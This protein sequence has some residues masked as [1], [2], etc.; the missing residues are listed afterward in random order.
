[1]ITRFKLHLTTL[2]G[3]VVDSIDITTDPNDMVVDTFVEVPALS[4]AGFGVTYAVA[5]AIRAYRQRT[6]EVTP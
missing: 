4:G 5:D 3:E 6:Q 1:M 2:Q